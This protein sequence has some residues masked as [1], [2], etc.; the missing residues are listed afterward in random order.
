QY[1]ETAFNFVSRLMQQEGVF[2]YFKHEDGK[3]T[4]VMADQ[5]GAYEDGPEGSVVYTAG[6]RA[7][8]H[9]DGW[10]HQYEF[11]SGKWAQTDYNF[12]TPKTSLLA[13]ADTVLPLP[14]APSYELFDYPGE[15]TVPADGKELTK[16]R[17]E[18]EEAAYET[19]LGSSQCCT[20]SPGTKF[21]VE[22]HEVSSE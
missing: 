16:L 11:R 9:I 19:V 7:P 12:E 15:Y 13:S 14:D 1:R 17:M 2:Y 18:E 4:L 20:F 22:E 8:N 10:E 21:T 3:H 6:S 5:T